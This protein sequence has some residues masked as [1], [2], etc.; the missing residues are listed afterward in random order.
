LVKSE[1]T[2]P[3]TGK[4]KPQVKNPYFNQKVTLNDAC[5]YSAE[6]IRIVAKQG[7]IIEVSPETTRYLQG[8]G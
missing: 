7:K 6:R 2:E 5:T 1:Y 8:G 3:E 4:D